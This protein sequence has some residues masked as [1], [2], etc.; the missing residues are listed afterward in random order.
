MKNLE[1]ARIFNRIADILEIEGENPFRIRAYRRAAQNLEALVDDIESIAKRR[2]LTEIPGIGK[3]LSA[4]IIEYL[5]TGSMKDYEVLKAKYPDTVIEMLSVPGIGPKK[6]KLFYKKLGIKSIKELEEAIKQGKLTGLP[7]IREKTL[8][9]IL[10][11]IEIYKSGRNRRL[12]GHVYPVAQH[13]KEVL[14]SNAPIKVIEIAGSF[15]RRKETVKDLDILV[16]SEE[17]KKVIDVFVELPLV[18]EVLSKGTT[19]SSILTT[20]GLQIDLR[21]LEEESFGSA[22]QYF[23]GSKQHNIH[24]RVI[25]QKMGLTI[26]EYGVF[27]EK[28][29]RKIAGKTEE[30]VYEAIGLTWIPPELREDRGEIEAALNGKLPELITEDD[31]RGDL[32]IHTNWSDGTSDIREVVNYARLLGL[33]YIAITDHS[34]SLTIAKGLD[35]TR[36]LEQIKQVKEINASFTD[37]EVLCGI[38]V[39]ILE[40]GSLDISDEVLKQLDIVVASI[41]T[42]FNMKKQEMTKRIVNALKNPYV[43]V[44]GHPTG[45]ML[46]ERDPYEFDLEEV[47]NV[48]IKNKVAFEVNAYPQRL[49]LSDVY[50]KRVIEAGCKIAINTDSHVPTQMSNIKYGVFC[51][52]RGWAEKKDCI[53]SFNILELK[54]WLSK[55]MS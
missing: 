5:Q 13:L 30:E 37:I 10:K 4:K 22:L 54:R 47:I 26:S 40:D 1:I 27:E 35:E 50:I 51:A 12:L 41:H 21:V 42:R 17:P 38:E 23:T 44:L 9:K 29:G 45:R 48:A 55:E 2:D 46:G 15:R 34:K 39:D 43:N 53:N 24:T 25:A 18:G 52:R 14:V 8:Q 49:D 33:E 36:L 20:D 28:T 16:I 3:D 6:V 32:H 31:I 19:R 11:G 7:G